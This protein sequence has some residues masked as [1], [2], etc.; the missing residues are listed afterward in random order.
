M[1]I[2]IQTPLYSTQEIRPPMLH[3][4]NR[5]PRLLV[6][7][8]EKSIR[9]TVTQ[10]LA[11]EN[12]EVCAAFNGEDALQQLQE[13]E[14]DLM[15]LDLQMPGIGGEDVL[16]QAVELRPNIQAIVIS[17][18]ASIDN[19]VEVMKLG[20]RDFLRK[21]F[22]P[23][24]LRAAVSEVFD[25]QLAAE[26]NAEG[27]EGELKLAR[28][29]FGQRQFDKATQHVKQAIAAD[30]SRPEAFNLLGE[31]QELAG[32]PGSALQN[33]RIA[34]QLDDRYAPALANLSR[35]A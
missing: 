13:S 21:P 5:R 7:D 29:W 35:M 4:L 23:S 33:Y 20:A 3:E 9:L 14:F 31:L 27:Y 17:A 34:T 19:A 10:T 16:R 8:D 11:G 28:H 26:A 30:P 15:L 25:R 2:A 1:P 22:T 24:E 12:Y 32:D 18:H 6:V